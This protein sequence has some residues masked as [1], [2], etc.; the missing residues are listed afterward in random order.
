MPMNIPHNEEA[1][2]GIVGA[3]MADP[4]RAASAINRAGV[5][6]DALYTPVNRMLLEVILAMNA[7]CELV[8]VVTVCDKLKAAGMLEKAGG[9]DYLSGIVETAPFGGGIEYYANMILRDFKFREIISNSKGAIEQAATGLAEPE[10]IIAGLTTELVGLTDHHQEVTTA[11]IMQGVRDAAAGKISCIPLP[12]PS[13]TK[14]TGGIR[15]GT[16]AILTGLGGAGKSMLK[17]YW[18]YYLGTIGVPSL[19]MCFEDLTTTAKL[20][21]ASIGKFHHA[22]AF[23]GGQ[24]VKYGERYEWLPNGAEDLRRIEASLTDLDRLPMHW[25]DERLTPD[26]IMAV[27]SD[28]VSKY[29]VQAIFVDGVKDIKRPA[30]RYSDVGFDEEISQALVTVAGRLNIAVVA[31][32]HLTKI[33]ASVPITSA[34]VRG[35][36]NIVNDCRSLYALQGTPLTDAAL[37]RIPGADRNATSRDENNCVSTRVLQC[38]KNNNGRLGLAW[39]ESDLGRC[40]FW[41]KRDGRKQNDD[42]EG[43]L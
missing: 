41:E 9:I 17:S 24:S 30:G 3:L 32:H 14:I 33:D 4:L 8:D 29:G 19:D 15:K 13:L 1:E 23:N 22:A 31:I 28:Y 35:S 43:Q 42:A 37:V 20:R 5:S 34:N 10:S 26:S 2:R 39:I 40:D 12:F 7:N 6:P 11:S 16:V 18:Q 27:A 36:G 38:L 25:Y 21:T